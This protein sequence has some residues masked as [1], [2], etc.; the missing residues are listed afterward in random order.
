MAQLIKRQAVNL[1]VAVSSPAGGVMF[2]YFSI[3][4]LVVMLRW[5]VCANYLQ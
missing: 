3:V 1:Q 2:Y 4:F 5:H